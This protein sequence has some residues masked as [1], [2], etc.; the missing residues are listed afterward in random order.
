MMEMA[1]MNS[2]AMNNLEKRYYRAA[3]IGEIPPGA[4]RLVE[5]GGEEVALFNF[6]GEYYAISDLCPHRGASLAE[7]FLDG[8]K[9]F[10][11]LHCFD[12]N[13]KTGECATVPS[14]RVRT[15]EVKISGE[16]IFVAC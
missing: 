4:G 7:G 8:G 6:N 13:L 16:D 10:C 12:F 11:P 3:S 5:V 14:L 2:D 1:P 9:V 15:Y